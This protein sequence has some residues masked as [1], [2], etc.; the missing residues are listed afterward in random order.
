M[1]GC[2]SGG[3]FCSFDE[4]YNNALAPRFV[5]LQPSCTGDSDC[6]GSP[7]WRIAMSQS[8]AF[9]PAPAPAPAP[10]VAVNALLFSIAF[11][12]AASA[13][14]QAAGVSAFTLRSIAGDAIPGG[15]T[16][17]VWTAASQNPSWAGLPA[18]AAAASWTQSGTSAVNG[19]SGSATTLMLSGPP[20]VSVGTGAGALL[21]LVK[22]AG[23]LLC[24]NTLAPGA[25]NTP[26]H[27]DGFVV[28]SQG[29]AVGLIAGGAAAPAVNA[30][31]TATPCAWAALQLTYSYNYNATSVA[32]ATATASAAGL[33]LPPAACPVS[34][35]PPP[36]A[37]A[38]P[39]TT[40]VA[41]ALLLADMQAAV[42][43]PNVTRVVVGANMALGGAPL[44]IASGTGGAPRALIIEGTSS[45]AC[46]PEPMCVLDAGFS[47]RVI[48]AGEG[49][50]LT[51]TALVIRNG[52]A[53]QGGNGGCV[54]I[55]CNSSCSLV[56]SQATLHHCYAAGG[57]GGAL[58]LTPWS[59][60]FGAA[61]PNANVTISNS[62]LSKN[63]AAAGGA[64]AVRGA[65][66][67]MVGVS[68]FRNKAVA[69]ASDANLASLV[70]GRSG[71]PG[72]P[73][74]VLSGPSGGAVALLGIPMSAS[75]TSCVFQSN[76]ATTVDI[77]SGSSTANIDVP[78]ARAGGVFAVDVASVTVVGSTFIGNS[79]S[80]GGAVYVTIA[81]LPLANSTSIIL[82]S[83]AFTG[84]TAQIGTGGAAMVDNANT[85]FIN[86]SL[87][88]NVA[89]GFGGGGIAFLACSTSV[90]SCSLLNN[91]A[92]MGDGGAIA[93]YEG[94][95]LNVTNSNLVG[96]FAGGD[97][98]GY[99][100]GGGGIAC[101]SCMSVA[102]SNSTFVG[103]SA[104]SVASVLSTGIGGGAIFAVDA[105]YALTLSATSF[106]N[107]TAAAG[108][109]VSV[110]CTSLS[111]LGSSFTANIATT[112]HG[113]ALFTSCTANSVNMA[114]QL[115]TTTFTGNNAAVSGGAVAVFGATTADFLNAVFTQNSASSLSPLGGA[116]ALFNVVN[117]SIANTSFTGNAVVVTPTKFNDAT[118][119]PVY[120]ASESGLGGAVWVSVS[121]V[122][123]NSS[124]ALF[125]PGVVFTGNSAA[126][127]GALCAN[128]A[129][130]VQMTGAT[131]SQNRAD[132]GNGGGTGGAVLT[133]D[134]V[135]FTAS[136]TSF[137]ANKAARGGGGMHTGSSQASYRKTLWQ[138][139]MASPDVSGQGGALALVDSSTT[140]VSASTFS[141]NMA[142]SSSQSAGGGVAIFQSAAF[143]VASSSFLANVANLGGSIYV[144]VNVVNPAAQIALLSLTFSGNY[145]TGA[146]SVVYTEVGWSS[147]FPGSTLACASC[148]FAN[149]TSGNYGSVIATAPIT[150]SVNMSNTTR[151]GV[152]LPV[153]IKLLDGLG[154]TPMSWPNAV[155]SLSSTNCKV[156]LLSR[157]FY[158]NGQAILPA[159]SL[160][161]NTTNVT[162]QLSVSMTG[163]DLF[164]GYVTQAGSQ[165]LNVSISA[166]QASEQFDSVLDACVCAYGYGLQLDGSCATCSANSVTPPGQTTCVACPA[167]SAPSSLSSCTCFPGYSGVI[168]GATGFC[169]ACPAGFYRSALDS[170]AACIPC[171]S[172][173]TTVATGSVSLSACMCPAGQVPASSAKAA[174]ISAAVG[175]S[176]VYDAAVR[177]SFECAPLPLGGLTIPGSSALYA[178]EGYW[179][180]T[181]EYD[182][183]VMKKHVFFQCNDGLCLAEVPIMENNATVPQSG[184]NCREGHT[185]HLCAVCQ[186]GWAY[187]GS[188]CKPCDDSD[189]WVNWPVGNQAVL[190]FF[191][192]G[193]LVL[194]LWLFL[195]LP[196]FPQLERRLGMRVNA[197]LRK[198]F[199]HHI[200]RT[201]TR[202][203]LRSASRHIESNKIPDILQSTPAE[204]M[205]SP[206]ARKLLANADHFKELFR[207]VA[208]EPLRVIVG[209]WQVISSFSG[210][211]YVPWPTV[212]YHYASGVDVTRL[213]FLKMPKLACITPEVSFFKIF[214]ATTIAC[215]TFIL[216]II[217]S[218]YIG[219][220]SDVVKSEPKR[221][222]RFRS[223]CLLILTWGLF[224]VYPQVAQT[225]LSIYSCTT[226]E[227]GTQWLS[228]D[229]RIQCWTT[230]HWLHAGAGIF[231]TAMFPIGIPAGLVLL[232]YRA[233]VPQMARYKRD[234]AWVK[235]MIER[236]M[237]LGIP[238]P[239][240]IDLDALVIDNL[241]L[242]YIRTLH[243]TY[244]PKREHRKSTIAADNEFA[245]V[246]AAAP[247]QKCT[248]LPAPIETSANGHSVQQGAAGG[249]TH[250]EP[251]QPPSTNLAALVSFLRTLWIAVAELFMKGTEK[252]GGGNDWRTRAHARVFS[253]DERTLLI[254]QILHW[255]KH[256]EDAHVYEPRETQLRWRTHHDWKRLLK[257]VSS[258]DA[259]RPFDKTEL[260]AHRTVAF[261]YANYS[262]HAWYWEVVD[263][264]EKL[265]LTGAPLLYRPLRLFYQYGAIFAGLIAF[266]VPRTIVQIVAALLFS[267]A[268][269]LITMHVR[270][271]KRESV[272]HL[273]VLSRVNIVLFLLTGLLLSINPLGFSDNHVATNVIIGGLMTSTVGVSVIMFAV[274]FMREWVHKLY[275][276]RIEDGMDA[277]DEE[278]EEEE[279]EEEGG[280]NEVGDTEGLQNGNLPEDSRD[281]FFQH[282]SLM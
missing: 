247:P 268:M 224:L 163:D 267:F 198:V 180:P 191:V 5:T 136:N 72:D 145:A 29:A 68:F 62:V 173:S 4:W 117:A 16:L 274:S 100:G 101:L 190:L 90:T 222:E 211:L 149:N 36:P 139:N 55:S 85:A 126:S 238:A 183:T 11:S 147:L 12:P 153:T 67:K 276:Q 178:A 156:P 118:F 278:E 20:S 50:S 70:G 47:S 246:K 30:T 248:T 54:A 186:E 277:E 281:D 182:L 197:V 255:A 206:S 3:R 195:Y 107:N 35:S 88:G 73:F 203:R 258:A 142:V 59:T 119:V 65:S 121:P 66:V 227:N 225:T 160:S 250:L 165:T 33:P 215:F 282:S 241:P 53:P 17:Q 137:V 245:E 79:A 148:M 26:L 81:A 42:A 124:N 162:C 202:S 58:A 273:A 49:V 271:Y 134:Q 213:E 209:F 226:L 122:T 38:L 27:D 168:A 10:T 32:I 265:F 155:A 75:F 252:S 37:A 244:L 194:F 13:L 151:S 176:S 239:A 243:S 220:R 95:V 159:F 84:N 179:R 9:A 98:S 76:R 141:G 270:P 272:N 184:Y 91:S 266:I 114:L 264:V 196:L 170:P 210:T 259:L 223:R 235:S 204:H 110:S 39:T 152:K 106:S 208:A 262:H 103:N 115:I 189:Q 231:W 230:K 116:L 93:M 257:S 102:V 143:G 216:L 63:V 199:G 269:L 24:A 80:F 48:I 132:D 229:Y 34:P 113:G 164:A 253:L 21:V 242:E 171:P 234:T 23:Q 25:A 2:V 138:Q 172:S 96:N 1:Y 8:D 212:Y 40:P 18:A 240:D 43:N 44:V 193:T 140:T 157:A 251:P 219:M 127:G 130:N 175:N 41:L 92:P 22:V 125:G 207:E 187:Q 233:K 158:A 112:T 123:L 256:S 237:I 60:S 28:V 108:G 201:A 161:S 166:C 14:L 7:A 214:D 99:Y 56:V 15:A 6:S 120:V 261:L 97:S 249:D 87:N 31:A 232:L 77:V 192:C 94:A 64:V 89:G 263:A 105:A 71:A 111:A 177:A 275:T 146:G 109:A 83:S 128:G 74:A 86:C 150:F 236:A 133:S 167:Y 221:G 169:V 82:R 129:A 218:L 52:V 279:E 280:G 144:D 135:M 78:Q 104:A 19:T 254:K 181:A 174:A 57:A 61:L 260:D 185:G 45:S 217:F 154:N 228:V 46:A 200:P 188:F 51:L 69:A 131:F 205:G